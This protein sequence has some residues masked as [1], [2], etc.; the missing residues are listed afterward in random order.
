MPTGARDVNTI[1]NSVT[2]PK[3][4]W[5]DPKNHEHLMAHDQDYR[6]GYDAVRDGRHDA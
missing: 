1:A 5:S 4:S 3:K 6:D 2:S